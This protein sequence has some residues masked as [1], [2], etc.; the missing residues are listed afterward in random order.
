MKKFFIAVSILLTVGCSVSYAAGKDK[1]NPKA[2]AVLQKEF[3]GAKNVEWS[4]KK[5][6]LKAAFILNDSRV[7]AYFSSEG[8]L[9]GTA[10][11]LL[12]NQ[13]PLAVIKQVDRRFGSATVYEIVEYCFNDE[14]VYSMTVETLSKKLKIKSTLSGGV[15]VEKK[16][17]K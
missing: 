13:L 9:I 14:T 7:E 6:F 2:V 3:A 15:W 1:I 11:N 12:F 4:D 16:I 17:K 5:E 8:E 10:R